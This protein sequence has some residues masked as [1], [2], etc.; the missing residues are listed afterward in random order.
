MHVSAAEPV[1]QQLEKLI[2][3]ISRA[4]SQVGKFSPVVHPGR[5][6]NC[7]KTIKVLIFIMI[8]TI[9]HDMLI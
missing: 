9:D 5:I 4:A 1:D 8:G 2:E 6:I 7:N 3:K